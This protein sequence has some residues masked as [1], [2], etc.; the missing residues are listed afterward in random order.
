MSATTGEC[1]REPLEATAIAWWRPPGVLWLGLLGAVLMSPPVA[2]FAN[3]GPALGRA[4]VVRDNVLLWNV[5]MSLLW[6]AALHLQVRRPFWLHLALAPLYLT[7]ATDLFLVLRFGSRLTSS[8]VSIVMT[9][10]ADTGNFLRLHRAEVL[11]VLVPV[12]GLYAL[13]L[14]GL[15]GVRWRAPAALRWAVVALLA[16]GYLGAAWRQARTGSMDFRRACLDVVAH[17]FSSPVGALSQIGVTVA[18]LSET[19]RHLDER[20]AF[21]FGAFQRDPQPDELYVLVIGESARPDH[22]S[23]DGY[24]R[25]TSPRLAGERNLVFLRDVVA[26]ASLTS[27]SVPSMMSLAPVSDWQAVESQRSI[28]SA[29]REAGFDTAWF[30]TQEVSHWSGIIHNLAG[31]AGQRRYFERGHDSVLVDQVRA[32]L[33]PPAGP[34][35]AFIV[36]HTK[37]SHSDYEKRYPPKF[38]RFPET[39][40]TRAE[41]LV[42]AY[43]NSILYTDWVLAELIGILRARGGPALL[44]YA[45][46]HGENLLDDDEGLVGHGFNNRYDLPTAA[47]VWLSDDMV[48]RSPEKLA[49]ARAHASA[50]LSLTNLAHSLLDAAGIEAHGLDRSHSIFSDRFEEAPRL[51]RVG[52]TTLA[53]AGGHL[54]PLAPAAA[55]ER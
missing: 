40:G 21:T 41:N 38:R 43:D 11:A 1:R 8:Y 34:R 12:L 25:E 6:L 46:D 45:S 27:I 36:L 16:A 54:G 10:Y 49:A 30:S 50:P 9:D 37:G 15:R 29:F 14:R 33:A 19:N 31:E 26:T 3:L 35:R 18:L 7:T 44:V 48:G 24:R 32:L 52:G 39:G 55:P 20:R 53:W 13:G 51:C 42:S 23:I 22:W 4:E 2:A 47:F 5:A 28:V 17:D